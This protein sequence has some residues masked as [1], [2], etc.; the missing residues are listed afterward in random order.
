MNLNGSCIEH[1]RI[2]LLSCRRKRAGVVMI[3]QF[4]IHGD[5]GYRSF[6]KEA[7]R[8]PTERGEALSASRAI[9]FE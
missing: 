1:S 5:F 6:V 2:N 7:F 3:V 4:G 8:G 9:D